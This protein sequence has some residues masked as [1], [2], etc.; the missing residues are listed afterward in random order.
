VSII[1]K[2]EGKMKTIN[3]CR[4][5]SILLFIFVISGC[6]SP[7]KMSSAEL[8]DLASNEGII[9]GS[10]EITGGDDLTGRVDWELIAKNDEDSTFI[11]SKTYSIA[12]KRDGEE[13]IFASKLPAG[14]Y[15]FYSL[16]QPGF[17]SF[18]AKTNFGFTV[19]P[20]EPL[21]IGRLVVRFSPGTINTY[22]TQI[23]YNVVDAKDDI[24][25]KAKNLYDIDLNNTTSSLAKIN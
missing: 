19:Q 20:G 12:A 24:A 23:Y 6:A 18:E 9:V 13:E 11:T 1:V 7:M 8:N 16:F 5:C 10:L 3:Y 17:S 2:E 15:T 22:S 4:Y 14:N 21:Y 25:E